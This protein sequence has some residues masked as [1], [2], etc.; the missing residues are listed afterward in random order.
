VQLTDDTLFLTRTSHGWKVM[1][2]ACRPQAEQQPYD[3]QVEGS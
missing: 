2:A 3:C 1:A